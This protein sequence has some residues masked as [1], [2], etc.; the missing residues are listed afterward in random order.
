[1]IK[2]DEDGWAECRGTLIQ[3]TY[4]DLISVT[5]LALERCTLDSSP[6]SFILISRGRAGIT[7]KHHCDMAGGQLEV[8]L[9]VIFESRFTSSAPELPLS[10]FPS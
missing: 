5:T 9:V 2:G 10:E 6:L 1:M 7:Q 4:I 3:Y 8:M